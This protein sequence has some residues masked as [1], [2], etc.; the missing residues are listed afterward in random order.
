LVIAGLFLFLTA[1]GGSDDAPKAS[2]QFFTYDNMLYRLSPERISVN[3]D[4]NLFLFNVTTYRHIILNVYG[5]KSFTD[6]VSVD[7][8]LY[9]ESGTAIGGIR[10]LITRF[11]FPAILRFTTMRRMS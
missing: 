4:H 6:G 7:F 3:H 9:Y 10:Q 1:C 5:S 2:I 8:D 11:S